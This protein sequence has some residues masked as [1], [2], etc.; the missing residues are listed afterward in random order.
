MPDL[1]FAGLAE[2]A[3]QAFTPRFDEVLRRSRRRRRWLSGLVALAVAAG[4][5]G[6]AVGLAGG[7]DTAPPDGAGWGG[8]PLDAPAVGDRD[9]LYQLTR[10]C[11]PGRCTDHVAVSDDLGTSWSR[12][13]APGPA[14]TQHRRILLATGST[15]VVAAYGPEG[16]EATYWTTADAGVTWRQAGASAG[17]PDASDLPVF[18]EDSRVVALSPTTGRLAAAPAPLPLVHAAFPIYD[19]GGWWFFG[20]TGDETVP[21]SDPPATRPTRLALAVSRDAGRSWDVR[22]LPGD[23]GLVD[24]TTADGVL[25]YALYAAQRGVQVYASHDGGVTWSAGAVVPV[26]D[27]QGG[28]LLATRGGTLWLSTT[29]GVV[30][31]ADQGRSFAPAALE[32]TQL[33]RF[34]TWSG[35]YVA[36]VES[37]ELAES[38][39]STDGERWARL[40]G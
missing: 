36:S 38:W 10:T 9:R 5:G 23:D 12:R 3:R 8:H 16:A 14:D 6:L 26:E 39:L 17:A 24:V 30:R 32:A 21:G 37:G 13:A 1:D 4:G 28:D 29:A 40:P 27:P 2:E 22:A 18:A 20:A 11:E 34:H 31:S 33:L 35:A 25:V 15:A 7:G 19:G